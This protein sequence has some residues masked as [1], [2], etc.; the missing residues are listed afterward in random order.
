[1]KKLIILLSIFCSISFA[2][3]YTNIDS[4]RIVPITGVSGIPQKAVQAKVFG[5][6]KNFSRVIPII[7]VDGLQE[8]LN[9]KLNIADYVPGGGTPTESFFELDPQGNIRPKGTLIS[10]TFFELDSFGNIRPKP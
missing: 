8:L 3:N 7:G 9:A 1:M 2:Q 10:D 4:I 5:M 6:W